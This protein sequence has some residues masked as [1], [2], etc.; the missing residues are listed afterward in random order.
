MRHEKQERG[1]GYPETPLTREGKADAIAKGTED[2]AN[3]YVTFAAGSDRERAK[4][5]ALY[6][7]MGDRV[8]S[9]DMS[10]EE[11]EKEV[12]KATKVKGKIT[13][14]PELGYSWEG[15]DEFKRRVKEGYK[16]GDILRF[17]LE[18]S[19]NLVKETKDSETDSY[20]RVAADIASLIAREMKVGNNFN[21]IAKNEPEKYGE[22]GKLGNQLKRYLGTHS[23]IGECF[24]MKVLEK[25]SGM[26]KAR[27]FMKKGFFDFQEGF[28]VTIVNNNK[29]QRVM[30]EGV[31]GNE[32]I[33][34]TPEILKDIISDAKNLDEETK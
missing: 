29:G 32:D 4:Q 6:R 33:E 14:F 13:T 10:F 17:F 11:A 34:L 28:K 3:L 7:M 25:I 23:V 8:V 5:T 30:L 9:A 2:K 31:R 16:K 1:E 27:E 12:E 19:D 18:E 21:K 15:S 20:S 22:K 26:D 24:Y